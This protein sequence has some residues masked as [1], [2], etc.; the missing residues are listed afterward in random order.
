MRACMGPDLLSA[1]LSL[2]VRIESSLATDRPVLTAAPELVA[3]VI[4][5]WY[6]GVVVVRP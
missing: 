1:R 2:S 5:R 4:K 6:D 3:N